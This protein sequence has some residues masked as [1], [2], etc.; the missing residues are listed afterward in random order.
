MTK[1]LYKRDGGG[2]VWITF[3]LRNVTLSKFI[4]T[5]L[6]LVGVGIPSSGNEW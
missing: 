5:E 2:G 1:K 3:G 6:S 4:L